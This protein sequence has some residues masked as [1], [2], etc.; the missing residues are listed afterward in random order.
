M[1]LTGRGV[2][3]T[4]VYG[5]GHRRKLRVDGDGGGHD[6]WMDGLR[7][8]PVDLHPYKCART[9][10]WPTERAQGNTQWL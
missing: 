1:V 5:W 9:Q 8:N 3:H 4:V 10:L 6:V 2:D 7:G